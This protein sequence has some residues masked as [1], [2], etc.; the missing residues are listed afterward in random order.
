MGWVYTD[1]K[2]P[3]LGKGCIYSVTTMSFSLLS[4]VLN[5]YFLVTL[6]LTGAW[7]TIM[8]LQELILALMAK[9]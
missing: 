9:P 4:L 2:I 7:F 8:T 6:F 5:Y 1:K 3:L